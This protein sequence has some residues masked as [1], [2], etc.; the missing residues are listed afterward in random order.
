MS[1]VFVC[2]DTHGDH[3]IHKLTMAEWP[4]QKELTKDDVLIIL[5]DYG[6]LW[7]HPEN[8]KH[9]RDKYWNEWLA[10]KNCTVCFIDGNHENF[11]LVD[12][13]PI[14]EKWGAEVG[15]LETKKGNIYHLKRGMIYNICDKKIFTFGGAQSQDKEHRS[16]GISWWSREQPNQEEMNFGLDN[17][18]SHNNKV[19]YILT[20][21]CSTQVGNDILMM[22]YSPYGEQ[23]SMDK[24]TDPLCKYFDEIEFNVSFEGWSF[25]H[26]HKDIKIGKIS[27]H[28]N[29]EPEELL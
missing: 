26:F 13:L 29:G 7:Y 18:K 4:L 1:K 10:D 23:P 28:Y 17:L 15:V 9:K 12:A 21:T 16:E 5:G 2:G 14:E 19:D 20:H 3:D 8:K 24:I 11:D 22:N 25:G 27:C 6:G